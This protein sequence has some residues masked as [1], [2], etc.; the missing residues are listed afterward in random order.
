[1]LFPLEDSNSRFRR[2]LNVWKVDDFVRKGVTIRVNYI[3]T[4]VWINKS[5]DSF[6]CK[7]YVELLVDDANILDF[8]H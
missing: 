4:R 5:S 6:S 8:D 3:D 7:S 1:M 2:N